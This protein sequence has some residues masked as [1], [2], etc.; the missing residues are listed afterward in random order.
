MTGT[1][2]YMSELHLELERDAGVDLDALRRAYGAMYSYLEEKGQALAPHVPVVQRKFNNYS[3]QALEVW[4]VVRLRYWPQFVSWNRWELWKDTKRWNAQRSGALIMYVLVIAASIRGLH[5]VFVRPRIIK[6][7]ANAYM[8]AVIP[9]PT[10]QNLRKLR[11]AMRQRKMS[12]GVQMPRYVHGPDG[13][14]YEDRSL[15]SENAWDESDHEELPSNSDESIEKN[16][17]F[18]QEQKEESKSGASATFDGLQRK[19]SEASARMTWQERLEEWDKMIKLEN[20]KEELQSQ[21][22]ELIIPGDLEELRTEILKKRANERFKKTPRAYLFARKWWQYRPKLPY[23]YFLSKVR[24]FEV[25]EAVYTEDLRKLFVTM[26]EGFPA[27]YTVDI[28]MDPYLYDLMKNYNVEIDVL[29]RSDGYY[30]LRALAVLAPSLLIL[31]FI[32]RSTLHMMESSS[33]KIID[34][35]KMDQEHLILPEDAA[36]KARSEYKDVV[37]GDAVWEALEEIMAYMKEPMRYYSK[38]LF[39]P[40]GILISGPPGT[41][42]TLLARALARE[43]GHPFVFA[44][45]AEFVE[46]GAEDGSEK[47]FNI[48]F[49]ARANAPSFIFID[50]IDALAGKGLNEDPERRATFEQLLAEL[51]GLPEDTD[52]DR[53][54]LRQAVVLICATNRA[55]ELDDRLLK[56]GRIDREIYIGLPGEEERVGIFKVHSAGRRLAQDVDFSKFVFR[57]VGC[58]GADIRNLINEAGIM[59]VRR[60]RE[61]ICQQDFVDVLDKQL[62]EGLGMVLTDEEQARAEQKVSAETKRLLAVHE[63]GHILLSH[64]FPCFDWHA[65]TH[66]LPGGKESALSLFYPRQD[67]LGKGYTTVGYLK[68]QMVVAHG[69][70]CAE[71]IVFGDDITD[72]GQDDL[73]KISK[74]AREI[75]ISFASP[76]LGLF[77]MLWKDKFDPP[78]PSDEPELIPNNWSKPGNRIANMSM[79][80]SELFTREVTR[81]VDE[82]EEEAMQGLLTNRHILDRIVIEL[83]DRTKMSGLD[84]AEMI[85]SMNPTMLADPL[86]RPDIEFGSQA[87]PDPLNRVGHYEYLDIFQA[88]LHS[89]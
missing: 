51:D 43:S 81:Y 47:V 41:G 5:M 6:H 83:L 84:I 76:R 15:I 80:V 78:L 25:E 52:V 4:D 57:T 70:R 87:Q 19:R 26:K 35:L 58:S 59:A 22:S 50:E 9:L 36:Q 34:L 14:L 46:S 71:R 10:P 24:K 17:N 65:F 45:G 3:S 82:T 42:K 88:P 40:R 55:D 31:V 77:P 18:T 68:M 8:E 69:G 49:T 23:M 48:F 86:E 30:Y 63:A 21:E 73:A 37:I 62:F 27:D 44:S 28:P 16:L 53:F 13:K 74:I 29:S 32:Q 85:K 20:L 72:G 12:E 33:E 66:L 11:K 1:R 64:L 38:K 61:E 60:G 7:L 54:S 39:I 56:P 79:E 89:C 75:A 67:M 2:R